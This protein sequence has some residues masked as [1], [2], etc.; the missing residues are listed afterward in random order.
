[1][2]IPLNLP[3]I[4]DK[5]FMRI[6]TKHIN[7]GLLKGID[8]AIAEYPKHEDAFLYYRNFF[9]K[10]FYGDFR[11]ELY[12][13]RDI[14][15]SKLLYR[16]GDFDKYVV[17][18]LLA[19]YYQGDIKEYDITLADTLALHTKDNV[20]ELSK[21]MNYHIIKDPEE[22]KYVIEKIVCNAPELGTDIEFIL[23]GIEDLNKYISTCFLDIDFLNLGDYSVEEMK[24]LSTMKEYQ[25]MGIL[26]E[27][28]RLH[29][30]YT[31]IK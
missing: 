4:N 7:K 17:M 12:R 15:S 14:I 11:A 19:N 5:K 1:M 8:L 25:N 3:D 10:G 6:C 26:I 23:G 16:L 29:L 24:A 28:T 20:K 27:E 2:I 18:N 9:P 13:L 21:C 22:R 30:P 31:I